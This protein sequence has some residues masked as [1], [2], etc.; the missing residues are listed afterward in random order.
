MSLYVVPIRERIGPRDQHEGPIQSC[1]GAFLAGID[2]L[3]Q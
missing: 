2:Q 1:G 3:N